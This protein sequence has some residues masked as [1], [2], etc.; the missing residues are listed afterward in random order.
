MVLAFSDRLRARIWRPKLVL[1]LR[2]EVSIGDDVEKLV[3][4]HRASVWWFHVEVSNERRGVPVHEVRVVVHRIEDGEGRVLWDQ[5]ADLTWGLYDGRVRTIGPPA[6]ADLC[7]LYE[8]RIEPSGDNLGR[9]LFLLPGDPPPR[10]RGGSFPT[11]SRA[12]W[13]QT[14]PSCSRWWRAA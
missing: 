8:H 2:R 13:R 12:A 11:T 6:L 1:T 14:K 9:V 10:R 4:E 7:A 3:R 5:Y